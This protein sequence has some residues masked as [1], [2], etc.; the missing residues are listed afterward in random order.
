[1]DGAVMRRAVARGLFIGWLVL[2]PIALVVHVIS[3]GAS[4]SYALDL[5]L[6][7]FAP[8][9]VVLASLMLLRAM[10]GPASRRVDG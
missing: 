10:L 4:L 1:M 3:E 8:W 7:L 2:P 5:A 9:V 6:L